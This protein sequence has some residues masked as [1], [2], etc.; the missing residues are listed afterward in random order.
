MFWWTYKVVLR[1]TKRLPSESMLC[2]L[3]CSETSRP[4]EAKFNGAPPSDRGKRWKAYSN[5]LLLFIIVKSSR[6]GHLA[7][8]LPHIW[9]RSAALSAGL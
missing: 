6:W 9:P 4:T 1:Y 3:K 8:I 7:G 5:V 2:V